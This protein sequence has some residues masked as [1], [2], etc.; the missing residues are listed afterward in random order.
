M[1]TN[2]LWAAAELSFKAKG[3]YSLKSLQDMVTSES[4]T[5]MEPHEKV[6]ITFEALP[7]K[8]L[9]DRIYGEG[10]RA[11]DEILFTCSDGYQPSLPVQKSCSMN[12]SW[13]L[14]AKAA[15]SPSPIPCKIRKKSN[16]ARFI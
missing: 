8:A 10:W 5:V 3:S 1:L 7:L 12:P 13:H 14:P 15:P 9:L 6:R 4:V 11:K 16:S 2:P